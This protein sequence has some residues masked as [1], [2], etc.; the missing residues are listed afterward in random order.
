MIE[1]PADRVAEKAEGYGGR[2]V[3]WWTLLVVWEYLGI[4]SGRIRV[5]GAPRGPQALRVPPLWLVE[6]SGLPCLQLQICRLSSGPR[7]ITAK[8]LFCLESV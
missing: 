1:S 6:S 5:G 2:K 4:Y 3:F 7:K 8:V